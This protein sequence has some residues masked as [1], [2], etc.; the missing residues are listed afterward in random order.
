MLALKLGKSLSSS[1]NPY[2]LPTDESSLVA[3]YRKGSEI[4][5]NGSDVSSW[6]DSS[7]NGLDM[8]QATASEQ[9]SFSNN[10]LTF[11]SANTQNLQTSGQISLTGDFMVGIRFNPSAFTGVI[12]GDNTSTGE[13]FKL[14]ANDTIRV[15]IDATSLDLTLPSGSWG[16]DYMVIGRAS[17]L[18]VLYYNG[19]FIDTTGGNLT[20][21]ADIDTIGVRRVDLN[22]Y[23][24]T[25]TEI[26]IYN[27]FDANLVAKINTRLAPL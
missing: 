2:W 8:V 18:V 10:I 17:G 6:G 25:I 16:D 13:F 15:K 24:G 12:L 9:P 14:T 7:S 4:T 19:A 1:R 11:D 21:T 22:P 3:W 27:S 5:L 23:D 26:Q 20:G